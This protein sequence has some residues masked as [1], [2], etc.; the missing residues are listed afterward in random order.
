MNDDN[1]S[2]INHYKKIIQIRNE[3]SALRRGNILVLENDSQEILS[4]ARTFRNKAVLINCNLSNNSINSTI[5]L[6]KSSLPKGNYYL[7]DLYNNKEL[8]TIVINSQGG[9]ENINLFPSGLDPMESSI[10]L[11]STYPCY[12]TS[13]ENEIIISPNPTSS[14][15]TIFLEGAPFQKA[16]V[17][18]LSSDGKIVLEK[19]MK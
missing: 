11:L 14:S 16:L 17:T 6:L 7:T 19:E 5:S 15:F 12:T 9:F 3:Q 13:S 8:G 1:N 18:V 4:F 2:L 10:I